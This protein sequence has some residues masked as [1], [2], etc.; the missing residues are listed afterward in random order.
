MIEAH[1]ELYYEE[2]A[3]KI[4]DNKVK[5]DHKDWVKLMELM[6]DHLKM[7]LGRT[8]IPL[9]YVIRANSQV[10]PEAEND[11]NNYDTHQDELIAHAPHHDANGFMV[12]AF[13]YDNRTV[14][15]LIS[16]WTKDSKS[17]VYV[18]PFQQ[19]CD[20][21]GAYRALYGHYLGVN[22]V[23]NQA[24]IA[25]Y[26]LNKL[27]YRNEGR[28][29]NFETYVGNFKKQHKILK[30]LEAMDGSHYKAPDKGSV[31]RKFMDGIKNSGFNAC[32][33]QVLTNPGNMGKDLDRVVNLYQDF[34]DYGTTLNIS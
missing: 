2:E 14:W 24:R 16:G 25:E 29:W 22:T 6:E 27:E 3:Y 15:D 30:S 19:C 5:V 17:W 7:R 4:P 31:V 33:T 11:T 23:G 12:D 28:R 8:K 32:K 18:K 20:V 13:A 1:K 26:R 9:A 10:I 34:G 21:R